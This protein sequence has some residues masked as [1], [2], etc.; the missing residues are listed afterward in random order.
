MCLKTKVLTLTRIVLRLDNI[1]K[2]LVFPVKGFLDALPP[3]LLHKKM[4]QNFFF[5]ILDNKMNFI[6]GTIL[7]EPSLTYPNYKKTLKK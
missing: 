7:T 5:S 1:G 6:A 4:L 3:P 2:V